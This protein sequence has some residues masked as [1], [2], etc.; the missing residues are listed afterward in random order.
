MP[1]CRAFSRKFWCG[2]LEFFMIEWSLIYQTAE[3]AIVYDF[4]ICIFGFYDLRVY[5]PAS[6]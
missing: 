1:V 4:C 2:F 5:S 6:H 3:V